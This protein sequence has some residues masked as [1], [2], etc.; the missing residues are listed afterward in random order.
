MSEATVGAAHPFDDAIAL[1]PTASV[2]A[3]S[4]RESL[5]CWQGSS[6]P[7]YANMVG[8]YGGVMAAQ[9][10]NA[11]LQHPD[12]LGE[13]IA[14][15]V[16][17]AA[18]LADGAFRAEAHAARTNRSTQHWLV[19][20]VQADAAGVESTMITA[21]VVT[22]RRRTTWSSTDG[23]KPD[24]AAPTSVPRATGIPGIRSASWFQR[25][26][27][28]FLGGEPPRDWNDAEAESLTQ[29]WAR[30]DPPRPLDFC[31]LAALSDLF[32]PRVW[33]RRA[34][35]TPAGTVSM[36]VYFHAGAA[37]LAAVGTGY[38]FG[39][40]RE[41]RFFNGFSDQ[42]AEL[43]SEAGALLATSHQLVYFKE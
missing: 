4:G 22:A 13:P 26:E 25:Y 10:L 11:V 43:W 16:N 17:F 19:S 36:T 5:R 33:I 35:M 38:L 39:Q 20:L 23:A 6:P 34:R 37:E 42:R 1:T 3:Q 18:A 24:V 12:L 7:A 32:F 28:R 27:L 41:Q 30:D 29:L 21:S 8:P 2:L 31:S 14:L 15:T 9:A 40:A